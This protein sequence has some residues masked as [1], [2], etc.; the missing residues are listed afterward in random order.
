[1]Y[2]VNLEGSWV[3]VSYSQRC[4]C[5]EMSATKVPW[6]QYWL[7]H[8]HLPRPFVPA[9]MGPVCSYQQ[10]CNIM[11]N[12]LTTLKL[13][14]KNKAKWKYFSVQCSPN[15]RNNI[16]WLECSQPSTASLSDAGGIKLKMGIERWWN[17]TDS[18]R[19]KCSQKNLS[20]CH[21]AYHKSHMDWP[22]IEPG[23]PLCEAGHQQPG[24][25]HGLK[26]DAK[27]KLNM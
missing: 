1:M 3:T 27:S 20:H 13:T 2:A 24:P 19:P 6:F 12:H 15:I 21:I 23:P 18:G 11:T 7:Q 10:L 8:M 25:W 5:L 22:E 14:F 26:T 9:I 17:D 16:A 4:C